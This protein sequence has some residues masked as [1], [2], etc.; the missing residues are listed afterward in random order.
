MKVQ[1]SQPGEENFLFPV[2]NGMLT[3]KHRKQM[4]SANWLFL[5]FVDHTTIEKAGVGLVHGGTPIKL[6]VPAKRFGLSTKSIL[7]HLRRLERK[8]YIGVEEA[9]EG[10]IIVV[11]NS[12]KWLWRRD[13]SVPD[14]DKVVPDVDRS[15]PPRDKTVPKIGATSTPSTGSE[16]DIHRTVHK[17]IHKDSTPAKNRQADPRHKPIRDHYQKRSQEITG[18]K[19]QWDGADGEALNRWLR[20]EHDQSEG[21]LKGW[22][23]NA[24]N[25]TDPYP[26]RAGF[27]FTEF[28]RHCAKYARGPLRK[29]EVA[30]RNQKPLGQQYSELEQR[31]AGRV[32]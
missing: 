17:D 11:L 8:R 31:R 15:V 6:E 2:S 32:N 12:K 18:A 21:S 7:R 13:R 14:R 27:R 26:L 23:D 29:G 10:Y 30:S 19:A 1:G 28:E 16:G 4:G 5:W 25:S 24:F 20:R 3:A 22:L 9:A